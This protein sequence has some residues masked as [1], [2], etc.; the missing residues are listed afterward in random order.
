M[1]NKTG[2]LVIHGIG[3]PAPGEA[4]QNLTDALAGDTLALMPMELHRL[5]CPP[6]ANKYLTDFF[7]MYIRRGHVLQSDT[8]TARDVVFAEVF[9][10]SASQLPAGWLGVLQGIIRL[11][12]RSIAII[13]CA[14][15]E[16]KGAT[17]GAA[18]PRTFFALTKAM[19][20]LITGPIFAVNILLVFALL[21][22]LLWGDDAARLSMVL[23]GTVILAVG[24]AAF[25][26]VK[27]KA[28]DLLFQ[29]LRWP[30]F[31]L[32]GFALCWLLWLA[33]QL[34]VDLQRLLTFPAMVLTLSFVAV[35]LALL[36]S[37]LLRGLHWLR[38]E[39]NLSR[40]T[41]RGP[42]LTVAL[43]T[44]LV[45]YG[46]W[47]VV[48]PTLWTLLLS[49]VPNRSELLNAEY[50]KLVRTDGL[51]WISIGVIT[52]FALLTL[53]IRWRHI[54]DLERHRQ[55]PEQAYAEARRLIISP[56]MSV[57]L[58]VV[59]LA[60][61][62]FILIAIGPDLFQMNP[63]AFTQPILNWLNQRGLTARITPLAI[64]TIPL[65]LAP[66]RLAF[67]LV[68]D[69]ITY[70]DQNDGVLNPTTGP[71]RP[72]ALGDIRPRFRKVVHYLQQREQ[73][74]KLVVIAH[75]QGSVIALDELAASDRADLDHYQGEI[76]LVTMGS[77]IS[78][79]YQHYF[80]VAYPAWENSV[81]WQHLF[82][83]LHQWRH[84]YRIDDFVGM[85][86]QPIP[87]HLVDFAQLRLWTG[88]HN[89]YWRDVRVID[90][91]KK[92]LGL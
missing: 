68:N 18:V 81:R 78:H 40:E 1:S 90:P 59:T 32:A 70:V 22:Y 76:V 19:S 86:L 31:W 21:M 85:T 58:A 47:V 33:P 3:D 13:K 69:I 79:L 10:G 84:F 38:Y 56:L 23:Y 4:L 16:E 43:F 7:P 24:L 41:K 52:L 27:S 30:A 54:K 6:Q 42:T 77:P 46:L 83:R 61:V 11:F 39:R 62:S 44:S 34:P 49:R 92:I 28:D 37:I 63:P 87:T 36:L 55:Q 73:I 74:T 57:P 88:G 53:A 14:A 91:L 45:Q 82:A 9:W 26:I 5:P 2:I 72:E 51:Q 25:I 66:L 67:D 17:P 48:I 89:H 71:T 12:F 15:L 20:S 65:L 50:A 8:D 75:S 60:V 29:H 64:L 80:P 35:D